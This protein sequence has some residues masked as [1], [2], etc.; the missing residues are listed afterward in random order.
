M[1][2]LR[3]SPSFEH[4]FSEGNLHRIFDE[5]ISEARF[6]GLDGINLSQFKEGRLDDEIALISRKVRTGEY[7]F[8]R[9]REKL[10]HKSYRRLP[11]QIALPTIRDSITLRA[12]CDYL[13]LIFNDCKMRPPHE[14]TKLVTEAAHSASDG[15]YFLRIDVKNFYPSI[16]HSRLSEI[17]RGRLPDE[18]AANLVESAISTPVG[19]DGPPRP[20]VGVPQGLSISNILSMVYMIDFDNFFKAKF[21]YFRYVDDVLIVANDE[22]EAHCIHK[23]VS[24]FLCK[25]LSLY[26]HPLSEGNSGKTVIVPV[27]KGTDYLG[28]RITDSELSIR[29]KSY[30]KMFGTVVGRLRALKS[31]TTHVERVLWRLNL[32]ITG[33]RFKGRSIGWVLFFRQSTDLGQFHRMDA[34]V[35]KQMGIYGLQHNRA[36]S[37]VKTYREARYNRDKT[38]YIPNFD[39]FSFDDMSKTVSLIKGYSEERIHQMAPNKVKYLF[40]EIVRK[41]VIKLEE[42]T[43]D[44]GTDD[45]S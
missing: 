36:R 16:N 12:L 32:R 21:K 29:E 35:R 10:I 45:W 11:R 6:V 26:T 42:E 38:K 27:K 44:F 24:N 22:N 28:Y 40:W 18:V 14:V 33:C 20:N 17:L 3:H 41:E 31:N 13:G 4:C 8:T 39:N 9:F 15:A 19:F 34:F 43:V 1:S 7:R 5:R 2:Y 25:E 30:K 23:E 37:Y